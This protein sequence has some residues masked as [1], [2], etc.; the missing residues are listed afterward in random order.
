[1]NFLKSILVL[2]FVC[3]F[4]VTVFGCAE[5]DH[6]Q[7]TENTG[8]ITPIDS[9]SDTPNETFEDSSIESSEITEHEI[10]TVLGIVGSSKIEYVLPHE[11]IVVDF[12]AKNTGLPDFYNRDEVVEIMLP[13]LLDIKKAG[14]NL[15][16]DPTPEYLGR[17]PLVL[18]ILSE[19]S[20]VHIMT[21]TGFY[22][23]PFLPDF[24]KDIS[25]EDLADIWIDEAENGIADT[26]IKPGFIKIALN[27][28]RLIPVQEK[29]LRAALLTSQRT[30]LAIQ[31]HT[32][33]GLAILHAIEI[34]EESDFDLTRFIWVH[35]DAESDLTY[36]Y[37]AGNKGIWLEIDSI[38]LRPFQEHFK[39]LKSL[40]DEG[41]ADKILIS[42]DAGW[43]S[44]GEE[45]G[46]DVRAFDTIFTDFIPQAINWGISSEDL[47]KIVSINPVI[48]MS[49]ENR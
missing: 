9:S 12:S 39:M 35:A 24:V 34:M 48:A 8:K 10:M 30:G 14:V 17:D 19:L 28:G 27:T 5:S 25:V 13:Y 47:E 11:H 29:I 26:G 46:G 45:R 16:A 23:A 6:T 22:M 21:N 3:P 18:K 37:T 33:G 20:G 7:T 43:Y 38:G 32:V 31:A 1:M 49:L 4:M 15:L 41:L 44:I 36:L 42:Q 2:L 40:L